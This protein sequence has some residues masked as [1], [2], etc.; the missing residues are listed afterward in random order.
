MNGKKPSGLKI[1]MLTHLKKGGLET[2][3]F[4]L[5]DYTPVFNHVI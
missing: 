1:V 4:P 5:V 2:H 3:Q